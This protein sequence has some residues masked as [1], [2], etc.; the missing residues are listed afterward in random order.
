MRIS[1]TLQGNFC[2]EYPFITIKHNREII[3]EGYIQEQQV[4][5]FDVTL[6]D[7]NK[8][9]LQGLKKSNGINGK[10]DTMVDEFENIVADKNLLIKDIRVENISMGPVWIRDL[11][12]HKENNETEP[13]LMGMFTNG[14]LEF[15]VTAPALDWIIEQ[16]YI[17]RERKLDFES[18]ARSGQCKFEYEYV[19]EKIQSIKKIINDKN[20]NL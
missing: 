5:E 14:M 18:H 3:Y 11:P 7:H 20:L 17:K 16:K 2:N 19:T 6:C 4:L 10:W 9:S 15:D 1:F 12:L 13:C 8:I